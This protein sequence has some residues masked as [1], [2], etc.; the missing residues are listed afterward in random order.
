[1][2][3]KG[4]LE[5]PARAITI[6]PSP[7]AKGSRAGCVM[8][9]L[10]REL[11]LPP[12]RFLEPREPHLRWIGSRVEGSR[13][14]GCGWKPRS[15]L[16]QLV[17]AMSPRASGKGLMCGRDLVKVKRERLAPLPTANPTDTPSPRQS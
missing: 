17:P 15:R 6:P 13:K 2:L 1:M 16:H 3:P 7:G 9:E 5:G 10:L 12:A 14:L 4:I 11:T 8:G